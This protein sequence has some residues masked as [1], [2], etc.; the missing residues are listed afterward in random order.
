[1]KTGTAQGAAGLMDHAHGSELLPASAAFSWKRCPRRR[2]MRTHC[3]KQRE[4]GAIRN[5]V[6]FM[7]LLKEQLLST[8]P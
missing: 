1:M 5:R 6:S 7:P 4:H 3:W 2:G 8:K